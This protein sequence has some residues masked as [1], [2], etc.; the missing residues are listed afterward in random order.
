MMKTKFAVSLMMVVF[1]GTTAFA[2]AWEDFQKSRAGANPLHELEKQTEAKTEGEQ[3]KVEA[4][5]EQTAD[6]D[7]N[8]HK[9]GKDAQTAE[10]LSDL[11]AMKKSLGIKTDGEKLTEQ[12]KKNVFNSPAEA[13]KFFRNVVTHPAPST[14]G[15]ICM[16]PKKGSFKV[17]EGVGIL[18]VNT[19]TGKDAYP[20]DMANV[21]R[22]CTIWW[23]SAGLVDGTEVWD[24]KKQTTVKV[25]GATE[26][27]YDLPVVRPVE[28]V[29][30]T[31]EQFKDFFSLE[32]VKANE[33]KGNCWSGEAIRPIAFKAPTGFVFDYTYGGKVLHAKSPSEDV[34]LSEEDG[35]SLKVTI[36]KKDGGAWNPQTAGQQAQKTAP[37]K[38]SKKR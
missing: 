21:D 28:R 12:A 37:K 1:F 33:K 32:N 16:G 18:I 35:S 7:V 15:Q 13:K 34:V 6:K 17:P 23:V 4:E 2:S 38:G 26:E 5:A 30:M 8:G 14:N 20:G 25:G 3:P 10:K 19:D 9:G 36:R 27:K 31:P 22:Q 11:E 29:V 24:Q